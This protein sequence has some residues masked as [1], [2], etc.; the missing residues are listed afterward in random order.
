MGYEGVELPAMPASSRRKSGGAR[1]DRSYGRFPH[2]RECRLENDMEEIL[3][4]RRTAPR[5][6]P[7]PIPRGQRGI[8]ARLERVMKAQVAA[9]PTRRHPLAYH[10]HSHE[11]RP[12]PGGER[13][14]DR[15]QSFLQ[16]GAGYLLDLP[17]R[18][19]RHLREHAENIAL[20]PQGRRRSGRPCAIGEGKTS[21]GFWRL[22]EIGV[23]GG[24]GDLTI[25]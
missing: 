23:V 10:N 6:S 8:A 15:I 17:Q 20:V 22:P 14:I 18:R 9:S 21:P 4:I 3:A 25:R 5:L 2:V 1:K 12:L 11:F 13:P 24:R 19:G 16:A 7:A